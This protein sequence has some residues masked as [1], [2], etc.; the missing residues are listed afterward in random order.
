MT[1]IDILHQIHEELKKVDHP[2]F[3]H[4]VID[5]YGRLVDR[6]SEDGFEQY[7]PDR[8]LS[9]AEERA[10]LE[11]TRYGFLG[12]GTNHNSSD[13]FTWHVNLRDKRFLEIANHQVRSMVVAMQDSGNRDTFATGAVRDSGEGKLRPDLFSYVLQHITRIMFS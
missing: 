8:D 6:V 7:M 13:G 3:A 9:V 1:D 5:F 2:P 11:L 10:L 4:V 12:S